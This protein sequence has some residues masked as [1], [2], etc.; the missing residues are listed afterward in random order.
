MNDLLILCYHAVSRSWPTE[1]A[2]DPGR[3]EGQIR[4]LLRHG[5][6]PATLTAAVEGSRQGKTVVVT[7]D[8]AYRS[9][10]R[11]GLPVLE[12]LGV[13]ATMFVPSAFAASQEPMAWAGMEGWLGTRFETELECMSWDELRRLSAA[14]WEIGSHS[15]SHRDL[16]SLG[17]AELEDELRGSREDCEAEIQQSCLALAYPYSAYDSRVKDAARA[18]SYGTGAILDNHLAIP[19]GSRPVSGAGGSDPFELLRSGIYRG[20]GRP[21]FVAKTSWVSR[22]VRD[23]GPWRRLAGAVSRPAAG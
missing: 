4:S 18:A 20:D 17:D 16:T 1:F 7:F 9:V 14:G 6:R 2:I 11:E 10:L 22:R 13:P 21:R 8:D 5:Y 23:S 3:L 15:R 12:R 19:A